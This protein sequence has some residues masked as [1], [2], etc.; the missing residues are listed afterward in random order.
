MKAF[1]VKC[2]RPFTQVLFSMG[3]TPFYITPSMQLDVQRLLHVKC[4]FNLFD[5]K[6]T[7]D[8]SRQV[9]IICNCPLALNTLSPAFNS[10]QW[11]V[12]NKECMEWIQAC[13][14]VSDKYFKYVN[15]KL[16]SNAPTVNNQSGRN[17]IHVMTADYVRSLTTK[18]T[19]P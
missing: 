10:S 14:V 8:Y 2:L 4:L 13:Y 7:I 9:T 5:W 12:L 15:N 17:R 18:N 16:L 1:P 11:T 3:I 6:Q 19:L